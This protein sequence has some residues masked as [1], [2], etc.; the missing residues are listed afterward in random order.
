M[1]RNLYT[2]CLP[3]GFAILGLGLTMWK[4]QPQKLAIA[5][6]VIA[7]LRQ[8]VLVWEEMVVLSKF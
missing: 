2:F 7:S 3:S 6:I 4:N 1:K 8:I 5:K